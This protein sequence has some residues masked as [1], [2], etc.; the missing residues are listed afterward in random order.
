MSSSFRRALAEVGVKLTEPP[1]PERPEGLPEP[2]IHGATKRLAE[3]E[4]ADLCDT[5]AEWLRAEG[6]EVFFEVPLG[7][8]RP[9]VV[10]FAGSTTLAVE[11]KLSDVK[12]VVKQGLRITSRVDEPYIAMPLAAAGE[13]ARSLAY[14]ERTNPAMRLPGIMSVGNEVA[15]VRHPAGHPRRRLNTVALRAEAEKHGAERGGVPSTDQMARNAE[16]W[17]EWASGLKWREISARFVLSES[18]AQNIIKRIKRW[19]EHLLA[20]DDDPCIATGKADRAYFAGAHK[21]TL[22]LA[23]LPPGRGEDASGLNP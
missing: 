3:R 2:A 10:A 14:L 19:R 6:Y 15:I 8:G 13:A 4:E 23:S 21:H 17:R 12:G 5:V 7:K 1:A 22:I 18:G 20:C 16:I 11:A 9:D